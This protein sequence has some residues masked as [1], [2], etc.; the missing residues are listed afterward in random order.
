M[1]KQDF[2][3]NFKIRFYLRFAPEFSGSE[4]VLSVYQKNKNF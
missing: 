4:S 2:N 1:I 3:N